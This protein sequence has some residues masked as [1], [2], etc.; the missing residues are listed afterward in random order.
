MDGEGEN[1]PKHLAF[2]SYR[3]VPRSQE[4]A[5][6]LEMGLK[7]YARVFYQW[8]PS[9]FRDEKKIKPGEELSKRIN[10][11]LASSD[12]L[13]LLACPEVVKS[14]HVK[15]ELSRWCNELG[16]G[17]N[18]L[19]IIHLAGKIGFDATNKSIDWGNTDALPSDI[20]K[21]HITYP[22]IVDLRSID[23]FSLVNLDHGL[24]RERI[25][26]VAATLRNMAPE[27]MKDQELTT[28]RRNRRLVGIALGILIALSFGLFFSTYWALDQRDIAQEQ[29]QIAKRQ[30]L[31]AN[32][33][34]M[35]TRS[36]SLRDSALDLA[37][38]LALDAWEMDQTNPAAHQA[39]LRSYY[40]PDAFPIHLLHKNLPTSSGTSVSYYAQAF[41]KN[42]KSIW[43]V[44][45]AN[46]KQLIRVW[47]NGT[48]SHLDLTKDVFDFRLDP[49]EN[50]FLTVNRFGATL[51]NKQG[52]IIL[53]Y[54]FEEASFATISPDGS[55]IMIAGGSNGAA[56]VINRQGEVLANLCC[57][58][59]TI[60]HGAFAAGVDGVITTAGNMET[61]IW[62]ASGEL[63]HTINHNDYVTSAAISP[64]GKFV[65]TTTWDSRVQV[66]WVKSGK[67]L[68]SLPGH[69]SRVYSATFSP[70]GRK[71]A[72]ASSDGTIRIWDARSM[73][74]KALL[75]L[76]NSKGQEVVR[77]SPDEHWLVTSGNKTVTIWNVSATKYLPIDFLAENQMKDEAK[78]LDS[79]ILKGGYRDVSVFRKGEPFFTF[80]IPFR[81]RIYRGYFT[82]GGDFIDTTGKRRFP[83]SPM[84]IRELVYNQ[85][86][87]G[88]MNRIA[89]E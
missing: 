36:D 37:L 75:T 58:G 85:Q 82:E 50:G 65:A 38:S 9:I 69:S 8:P 41:D 44:D 25:N 31:R 23:D 64:N 54:P 13:I 88:P 34:L 33:N 35:I 61:R 56:I 10:E 78:T 60:E 46:P 32:S 26:D 29:T 14:P 57:H 49:V 77:W 68:K 70:D 12:F 74:T 79:F 43:V 63:L 83:F 62:S 76:P 6:A 66:W 3:H 16:H 1:L 67:L 11:A 89:V 87:F 52:K 40:E 15:D 80:E 28:A 47:L 45:R 22:L 27:E 24:F 51:W 18:N 72:T 59:N 84:A 7:R 5:R 2:I 30:L 71:L 86:R 39:V 17:G 42:S 55:K 73:S 19:I 53:E 48:S 81:D 4:A 20:L 21:P